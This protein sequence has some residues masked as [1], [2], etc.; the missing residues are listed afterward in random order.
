MISSSSVEMKSAIVVKCGA[1]SPESTM[2]MMLS[3]QHS[4]IFLLEM[5][6]HE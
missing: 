3:R 1:L 4:A 6:P 2:K 5:I